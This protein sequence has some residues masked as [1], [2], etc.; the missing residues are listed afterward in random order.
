MSHI[1][2]LIKLLYM[3]HLLTI[4]CFNTYSVW[5]VLP[6]VSY[7]QEMKHVRVTTGAI[8]NKHVCQTNVRLPELC[9]RF[10][11]N[12]SLLTYFHKDTQFS[13]N[14]IQDIHPN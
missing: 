7:S 2:I 11:L 6:S 5:N 12:T 14:I 9:N 10:H 13:E 8:C 4:I 1:D 3:R